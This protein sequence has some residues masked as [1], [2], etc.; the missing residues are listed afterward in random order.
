MLDFKIPEVGENITSGNVVSIAVAVGDTVTKDQDLLELETD[1]ASIP[2][3]SPCDGVIKEILIKEGE[4]IKIGQLAMRIAAGSGAGKGLETDKKKTGAS[5]SAAD[6]EK[7][8]AVAREKKRTEEPAKTAAAKTIVPATPSGPSE[9]IPAQVDIPA[10]PSVRRFAREIGIEI[11]RVPGSGPG[12]RVS[13]SDVKTYAKQLLSGAGV[14]SAGGV[15]AARPLPDFTKWGQ[16]ERKP[17]NN[18]RKKTAEHLSCCWNT[19]PHVT[20]FDQAD[21]TELEKLRKRHSTKDRKLTV[22]PFLMKVVAAALKEFPQF[23]ATVDMA[24]HEI[25]YKQFIHLGVAVDTDR[26]LLV[27][28]IRN[29]DQKGIFQLTDELN[30][31]AERARAKKTGLDELQGGSMT[32]TNLGGIGGTKFTPI[33]NWPEV[34]ILGVSRGDWQPRYENGQFIPRFM[35][36]LSLSYDHRVIDGA[37]GARFLRWIVE[38]VEHPFMMELKG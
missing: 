31:A 14:G 30:E 8:S 36:P 11:S 29:I 4:V 33:V 35:L 9:D 37:D 24:A 19:I 2:V 25:I 3:P 17:M 32:L 20:Q 27:P 15:L 1:K 13:E 38:A 34:A 10:S 23:N 22:T 7:G 6:K 28:I 26:G 12:G 5:I 16:V 21:I 18:I